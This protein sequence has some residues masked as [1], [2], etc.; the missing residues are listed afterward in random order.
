[1][2]S[3][4]GRDTDAGAFEQN[5]QTY[6]AKTGAVGTPVN[7]PFEGDCLVLKSAT[8][9]IT[10]SAPGLPTNVNTPLGRVFKL[11]GGFGS[12]TVLSSVAN[13]TV[14]F[15]IGYGLVIPTDQFPGASSGNPSSIVASTAETGGG[16]IG[17]VAGGTVTASYLYEVPFTILNVGGTWTGTLQV[18]T[19]PIGGGGFAPA[20]LYDVYGNILSAQNGIVPSGYSGSIFIDTTGMQALMLIATA[21]GTGTVSTAITSAH[22]QNTIFNSLPK[23]GVTYFQSQQINGGASTPTDIAF[24]PGN[25]SR[26][27]FV[28]RVS[29]AIYANPITGQITLIKRSALDTG[30]TNSS[31]TPVPFDSSYQA[32]LSI[33]KFY[34]AN[35]TGLG[36]TIGNV[37]GQYYTSS[38]APTGPNAVFDLTNG[39][40]NQGVELNGANEN[41]AINLSGALS[42][43]GFFITFEWTEI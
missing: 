32:A 22:T 36:T 5:F 30:G 11:N 29:L 21:G 39:G 6:T 16:N 41:L 13:D 18:E 31:F 14:T 1:M 25:A 33:P 23:R 42:T 37:G 10:I 43:P 12:L 8:G 7:I 35:P 28:K 19:R 9:N 40:Q 15:D 17:M 26:K 20:T 27:V 24:I 2:R 38:A 4:I 34:T 3:A